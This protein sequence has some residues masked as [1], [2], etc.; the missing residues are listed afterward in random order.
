MPPQ[1]QILTIFESMEWAAT[2]LN[3]KNAFSLASITDK[4]SPHLK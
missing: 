4:K 3:Q 1:Q 2:S